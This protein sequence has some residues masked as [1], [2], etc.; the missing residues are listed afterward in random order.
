M[1]T[2]YVTM[3]QVGAHTN[4]G[5]TAVWNGRNLRSET[6]TSSGASAAGALDAR[7]SEVALIYCATAVYAT[8]AT[9]PTATATNGVY[10]PATTPT[11]IALNEGDSIA[12]IDV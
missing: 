8:A 12:V 7:R 1:A 6:I 2:V 5:I 3:G 4:N 11:Y 10:V 9:S